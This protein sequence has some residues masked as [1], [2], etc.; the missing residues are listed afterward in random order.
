MAEHEIM[1]IGRRPTALAPAENP[2]ETEQFAAALTD[3]CADC[4]CDLQDYVAAAGPFGSWMVRFSRA[5]RRQ[6]LVWN[7]KENHLVL[8]EATAGVDWQELGRTTPAD[9]ELPALVA[10]LRS[11]LEAPSPTSAQS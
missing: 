3:A 9:R 8:E 11:L 1:W 5:G 4:G 7:G 6:R 2:A 10:A